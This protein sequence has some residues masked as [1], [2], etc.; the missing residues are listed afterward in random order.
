[1]KYSEFIPIT[2]PKTGI[3]L[4]D[5]CTHCKSE[6]PHFVRMKNVNTI[7]K[8][9][10]YDAIC[11][12]CF[13]DAFEYNVMNHELNVSS[14]DHVVPWI[15]YV[16]GIYHWNEWVTNSVVK[17]EDIPPYTIIHPDDE[18]EKK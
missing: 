11:W 1:M 7:R 4:W 3:Y 8:T 15:T 16:F 18:K 2:I 13:D 12:K 10:L 6:E 17:D 14:Y 9:V 5:F